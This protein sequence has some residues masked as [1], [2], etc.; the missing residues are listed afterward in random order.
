MDV[1]RHKLCND[2]RVYLVYEMLWKE[3]YLGVNLAIYLLHG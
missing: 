2:M 3:G 1:T